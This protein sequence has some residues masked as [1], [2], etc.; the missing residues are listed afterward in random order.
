MTVE[1]VSGEPVPLKDAA[2]GPTHGRNEERH[3]EPVSRLAPRAEDDDND[4][5]EVT[6]PHDASSLPSSHVRVESVQYPKAEPVLS[7]YDET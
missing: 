4:H 3:P 7:E 6:H 2:N 1:M 5:R